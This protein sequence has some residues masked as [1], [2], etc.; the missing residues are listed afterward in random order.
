M[1]LKIQK[2]NHISKRCVSP[3][4]FP[5][6]HETSLH[7]QNFC[8]WRPW[9]RNN[10]ET[11]LL[12]FRYDHCTDRINL[13]Y[14]KHKLFSVVS[15]TLLLLLLSPIHHFTFTAA[16]KQCQHCWH[17]SRE[18][19]SSGWKST[20]ER[21]E[22]EERTANTNSLKEKDKE[23]QRESFSSVKAV[24]LWFTDNLLSAAA[25]CISNKCVGVLMVCHCLKSHLRLPAGLRSSYHQF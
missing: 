2:P 14:R 21:K 24:S 12:L 10:T 15:L 25:T 13:F 5:A 9:G 18:Q 3:E 8:D 17:T 1:F 7:L 23:A 6:D 4:R 20:S 16:L 22:E 19:T 11:T